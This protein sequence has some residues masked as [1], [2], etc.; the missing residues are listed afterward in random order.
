M[1]CTAN[2]TPAPDNQGSSET[3]CE[4]PSQEQRSETDNKSENTSHVREMLTSAE[5]GDCEDP[6]LEKFLSDIADEDHQRE[7]SKMAW[8]RSQARYSYRPKVHVLTVSF[9]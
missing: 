7:K 4:S 5:V 9:T 3:S 1:L 8:D 6:E 2:K